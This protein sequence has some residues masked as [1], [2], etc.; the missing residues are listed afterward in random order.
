MHVHS[1]PTMSPALP[2]WPPVRATCLVLYVRRAL[3][4]LSL[5]AVLHTSLAAATTSRIVG[6]VRDAATQ[7]P[8]YTEIHEQTLAPD[9]TVQSGLTVYQTPDGREIARKTLDYRAHRTV[10]LYRMDI[11]AMRY[12]EGI[13]QLGSEASLFKGDRGKETIEQVPLGNELVAADAGFNQL[14]QDQLPR[15]MAG[16]TVHF[17]LIVPGRLDRYRFRARQAGQRTEAGR[18][19]VRIRVEPDSLLRWLVDAI[20]LDYDTQSRQLRRYEGVSN[21]LDP[22]TGKVYPRIQILYSEAQR[23]RNAP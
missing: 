1:S 4:A 3:Q 12:A 19:L 5:L 8:L 15:L 9:G 16:D 18:P 20:D 2:A 11:P 7:R 17:H 23:S 13:A 10:P 21:I 22:A 6:Q 14:L